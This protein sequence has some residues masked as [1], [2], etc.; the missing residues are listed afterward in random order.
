MAEPRDELPL[1]RA[2]SHDAR[3]AYH[4]AGPAVPVPAAANPA[5]EAPYPAVP[6]GR[7]RPTTAVD[8]EEGPGV[9]NLSWAIPVSAHRDAAVAAADDRESDHARAIADETAVVDVD[10][11]GAVAAAAAAAVVAAVGSAASTGCEDV[12]DCRLRDWH[13]CCGRKSCPSL[14]GPWRVGNACPYSSYNL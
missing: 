10:C 6:R 5:Y 11:R 14:R 8:S 1:I 4:R 2:A 7:P 13:D 9:V 3:S 12:L